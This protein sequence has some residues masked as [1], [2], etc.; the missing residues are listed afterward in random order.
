MS[1]TN[2][3]DTRSIG[4]KLVGIVIMDDVEFRDVNRATVGKDSLGIK[5]KTLQEFW[6][7]HDSFLK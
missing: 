2:M 1:S 5:T 6:Y 3:L 7:F 4:Y